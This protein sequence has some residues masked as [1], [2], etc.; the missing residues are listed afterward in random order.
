MTDSGYAGAHRRPS[1]PGRKQVPADLVQLSVYVPRDLAD[2]A[3]NAVVATTPYPD[4]YRRLSALVTDALAERLA[5]LQD[6][7]NDG[8]PSP[9]RADALARGRPPK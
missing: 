8:A 1:K 4:G 5:R 6:Q 3:R 9:E 2:A 7:F